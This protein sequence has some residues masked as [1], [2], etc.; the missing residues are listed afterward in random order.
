M[1]EIYVQIAL[2]KEKEKE[3]NESIQFCQTSLEYFDIKKMPQKYD[4]HQLLHLNPFGKRVA[5]KLISKY[6]LY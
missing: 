1:D 2:K 4:T 6:V 5:Q 3:T